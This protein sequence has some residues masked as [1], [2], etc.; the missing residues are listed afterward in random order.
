[1][2]VSE[3]S[4]NLIFDKLRDTVSHRMTFSYENGT[5][6]TGYV[7]ACRP[8]EGHVQVMVISR[9]EIIDSNGTIIENH[10]EM[11]IVPSV[12]THYS[13]TEGPSAKSR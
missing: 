9:A 8:A 7:A 13:I 3:N 10:K 6:V 4:S 5:S 2:G 11:L 12:L 1:M